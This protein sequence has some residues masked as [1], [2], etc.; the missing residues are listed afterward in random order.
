MVFGFGKKVAASPN[1]KS[2]RGNVGKQLTTHEKE[3]KW[4]DQ[5][6]ESKQKWFSP[7]WEGEAIKVIKSKIKHYKET[8][9]ARKLDIY[10]RKLK[11]K[12]GIKNVTSRHTTN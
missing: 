7:F 4:K 9:N 2:D 1:Q 5:K 11:G 10:T 12:H 3:K 8:G 6:E